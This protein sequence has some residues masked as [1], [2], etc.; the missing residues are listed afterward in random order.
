MKSRRTSYR[1]Y[2]F[3]LILTENHFTWTFVREPNGKGKMPWE[4]KWLFV[5]LSRH[6]Q[7]GQKGG[8]WE[9]DVRIYEPQQDGNRHQERSLSW[10]RRVR[11]KP[12]RNQNG[13]HP[14]GGGGR[15]HLHTG[16]QPS[17]THKYHHKHSG[18][19]S[20]DL[21]KGDN[22][23][24]AIFKKMHTLKNKISYSCNHPNYNYNFYVESHTWIGCGKRASTI[25]S[26]H[27]DAT[28]TLV[29]TNFCRAKWLQAS[30][31]VIGWKFQQM[32]WL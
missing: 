25:L 11:R 32:C 17:G 29:H 8:S 19:L 1:F 21:W 24:D 5:H 23:R 4:Q 2:R 10:A 27:W 18:I 31:S 22:T 28:K 30:C 13:L 12:V 26:P 14:R 9:S 20:V 15:T 6:H 16:R 3:Y 7:K